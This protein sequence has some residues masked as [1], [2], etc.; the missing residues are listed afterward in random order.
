MYIYQ[1]GMKKVSLIVV[2]AA[3]FI[4]QSLIVRHDIPDG[5]FVEE[6]RK[7]PQLCHFPMGEGVLIGE[8]IILTAGHIGNDLARDVRIILLIQSL[9][10]IHFPLWKWGCRM[11]LHS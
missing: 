2:F 9:Y 5:K 3:S 10:M 11:I 7:H 4:C 1:K 8:K 6:G